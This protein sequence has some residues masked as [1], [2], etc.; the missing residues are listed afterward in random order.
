[1]YLVLNISYSTHIQT[2][3]QSNGK[4]GKYINMAPLRHNF[5]VLYSIIDI[6]LN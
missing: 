4:Q 6:Q 1:M 3:T 2:D 5:K